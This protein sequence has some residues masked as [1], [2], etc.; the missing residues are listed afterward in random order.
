MKRATGRWRLVVAGAL[1]LCLTLLTG[2]P[3]QATPPLQQKQQ[4]LKKVEQQ[5]QATQQQLSQ[6]KK[7]ER[8]LTQQLNALE[9]QLEQAQNDLT[10]LMARLTSTDK[11]IRVT[12]AA[13]QAA[14]KDLAEQ[15]DILGERLRAMQE[16]G[17]A[18][19]LEVLLS[20]QDFG[21]LLDR[22]DLMKEIVGQDVKLMEAIKDKRAQIEAKKQDLEDKKA[23]L[24]RLQAA[25]QDKK[26]SI[27]ASSREKERL[28]AETRDQK[29]AYERAL[30]ELEQTSRELEYAI[31][32]LQSKD[33]RSTVSRG[34]GALAWPTAGRISSYFGYRVHPIFKTKKLHTGLD[35]AAPAG[36]TV[37]AAAD[38]TVIMADW[39][40]GYGKAVVIDHGGG[41]S[42]LY[43]H[44]SV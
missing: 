14:E 26:A 36:Q 39:Y 44:N 25:T 29:E 38:G 40:G 24:L 15:T 30:D 28:L 2:L 41:I 19:Y 22:F 6:T 37:V 35:I 20:S 13:L 4:E 27:E 32:Q 21:E 7:V 31:R 43:G 8:S 17:P 11:D 5:K 9:Q 10:Y 33:G 18:T 42:T 1:A 34:K 16:N 12:T 3:G 23:E